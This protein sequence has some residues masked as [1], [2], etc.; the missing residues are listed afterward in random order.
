MHKTSNLVQSA[1][2]ANV[3]G[4]FRKYNLAQVR[5]LEKKTRQNIDEA[6]SMVKS[7][8]GEKYPQILEAAGCIE[9]LKKTSVLLM[10]TCNTLQKDL[11][12][13][14]PLTSEIIVEEP[15]EDEFLVAARLRM[16]TEIPEMVTLSYQ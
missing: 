4:I 5:A 6:V 10:S 7:L 15:V 16:Y 2:L 11:P 13:N 8:V 3:D 12:A 14:L 9:E 1:G